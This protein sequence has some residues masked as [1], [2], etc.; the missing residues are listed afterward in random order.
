MRQPALMPSLPGTDVQAS[1]RP[2]YPGVCACASPINPDAP[3]SQIVISA[4]LGFIESLRLS[5]GKSVLQKR[6]PTDGTIP[7]FSRGRPKVL[8]PRA[9]GHGGDSRFLMITQ[10]QNEPQLARQVHIVL[11]WFEELKER[12][13]MP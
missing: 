10:P 9:Y 13:P 5:G 1:P 11:N 7:G 2:P 4:K 12:L 8:F 3:N 6:Q